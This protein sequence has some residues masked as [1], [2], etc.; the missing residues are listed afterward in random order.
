M[1]H[2]LHVV[3]SRL[4]KHWVS[5]LHALVIWHPWARVWVLFVVAGMQVHII[6]E[7][8]HITHSIYGALAKHTLSRAA[9]P[10]ILHGRCRSDTMAIR[11]VAILV[12]GSSQTEVDVTRFID[13]IVMIFGSCLVLLYVDLVIH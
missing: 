10:L 8:S 2:I 1:Y 9:V 11:A 6:G 3:V 12:G 4:A 13:P 5:Q 7:L